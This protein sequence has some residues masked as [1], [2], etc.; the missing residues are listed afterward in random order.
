[1][2]AGSVLYSPRYTAAW[3]EVGRPQ[4]FERSD[5]LVSH[6]QSLSDNFFGLAQLDSEIVRFSTAFAASLAPN[7]MEISSHLGGT[8]F[9]WTRVRQ[10]TRC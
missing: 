6:V 3:R 1:M 9:L 4:R 2:L 10:T 7:G 8:L 5:D